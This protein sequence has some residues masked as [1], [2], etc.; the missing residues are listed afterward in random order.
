MLKH[1]S[2]LIFYTGLQRHQH[3]YSYDFRIAT[4]DIQDAIHVYE[5]CSSLKTVILCGRNKQ[6]QWAINIVPQIASDSLCVLERCT[7]DVQR[8]KRSILYLLWRMDL[9]SPIKWL[10]CS[11]HLNHFTLT[12]FCLLK[13]LFSH[14]FN[15]F[16]SP[17]LEV[18]ITEITE[19]FLYTWNCRIKLTTGT[20]GPLCH[21]TQQLTC[22]EDL[23]KNTSL[24]KRAKKH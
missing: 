23:W 8:S 18:L 20:K 7:E 3:L 17:P 12:F 10:L 1:I 15:C 2:I 19:A 14:Y 24:L 16:V 21:Y 6:L 13:A 9:L 11:V 4:Q 5:V 22:S